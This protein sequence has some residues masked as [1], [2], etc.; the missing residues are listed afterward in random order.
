LEGAVE[1]LD[2]QS[3]YA[4]ATFNPAGADLLSADNGAAVTDIEQSSQNV[5]EEELSQTSSSV[6]GT[7][8]LRTQA[9]SEP[10]AI[11]IEMSFY[12]FFLSKM[13][14]LKA[15]V[16]A[17]ELAERWDVPK[18]Q[19]NDW[20]KQS[21]DEGRMQKLTKPVRY[22]LMKGAGLEHYAAEKAASESIGQMGLGLD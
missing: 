1:H 20:L 10:N 13:A 11:A 12:Q 6:R 17:D 21:V 4:S 15:A 3:L 9:S 19:I 16:T 7:V 5:A 18:K 8:D 14:C 22:Q 2:I